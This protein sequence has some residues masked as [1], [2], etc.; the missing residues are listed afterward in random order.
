MSLQIFVIKYFKIWFI[1]I[2][3]TAILYKNEFA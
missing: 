2:F 1:E 3:Y